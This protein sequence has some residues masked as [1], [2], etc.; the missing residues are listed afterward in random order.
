MQLTKHYQA[1][2]FQVPTST[3]CLFH[4]DS[5]PSSLWLSSGHS[6]LHRQCSRGQ[7]CAFSRRF[8]WGDSRSG[9]CWGE[10][11]HVRESGHPAS[12]G[13][14]ACRCHRLCERHI[15]TKGETL[16]SYSCLY[17]LKKQWIPQHTARNNGVLC[18]WSRKSLSRL[19][20]TTLTNTFGTIRQF[21][22]TNVK[23]TSVY[24]NLCLVWFTPL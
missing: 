16:L 6:S 11:G 17:H 1:G 15:P 22:L 20:Q 10:G 2:S 14:L 21:Y 18:P 5:Y 13:S 12:W 24:Q 9:P 3:Y 23:N 8:F 19:A 7:T 4:P